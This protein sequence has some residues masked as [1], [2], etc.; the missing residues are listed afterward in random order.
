MT[1]EKHTLALISIVGSSL[2]LLGAL[3]LAYDLLGGEHG[4][5]RTLTRIVTYGALF[6][7]G[8]GAIFG[9]V[10]GLAAGVTHGITLGSEFARVS[11]HG[12]RPGFWHDV[13]MSAI[14]GSGLALG[15]AYLYGAV[16]GIMFG[17]LSLAGQVV[18]YQF[19]IRPSMDYQPVAHPRLT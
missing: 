4:P 8:Y 19:G 14:R 18:A 1:I 13:A 3:Y 6:G 12:P 17:G 2:D 9:P 10:F 7:L 16:F 15:A 11:R 5:L